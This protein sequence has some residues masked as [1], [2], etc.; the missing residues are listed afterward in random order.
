M[1][2]KNIGVVF[3]ISSSW[4]KI[5]LHTE[6]QLPSLGI[7]NWSCLPFERKNWGRLHFY[8]TNESRLFSLKKN[9]GHLPMWTKFR[10]SSIYQKIEVVK[11]NK[12]VFYISSSWFETILHTTNQP[13]RLPRTKLRVSSLWKKIRS[14]LIFKNNEVVFHIL[15]SW[16][17]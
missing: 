2:F 5:R 6:N 7:K 14:T 4:V 3:Y 15:S 10:S 8:F 13:S 1:I 9:W 11:K 16:A 12:V 17:R